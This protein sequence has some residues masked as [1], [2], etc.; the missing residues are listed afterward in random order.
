[1][2]CVLWTGTL[3]PSFVVTGPGCTRQCGSAAASTL[4]AGQHGYPPV[5]A[6]YGQDVDVGLDA[7]VHLNSGELNG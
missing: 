2:S 7:Q 3:R 5:C 1:M 6:R 4:E